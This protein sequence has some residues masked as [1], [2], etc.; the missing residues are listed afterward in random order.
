MFILS[1]R[2]EEL[3]KE[4]RVTALEVTALEKR[5]E[6]WNHIDAALPVERGPRVISSLPSHRESDRDLPPEVIKLEVSDPQR[7]SS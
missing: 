2:F 3:L 5:F 6:S 1:P 7:S 4:E